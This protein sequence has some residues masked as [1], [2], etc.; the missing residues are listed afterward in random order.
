MGNPILWVLF[1]GV[2]TLVD[3]L[4]PHHFHQSSN[5]MATR[6]IPFS[7]QIGRNLA[8]TKKRVLGEDLVDLAHQFQCFRVESDRRVIQRVI[9]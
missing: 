9:C 6:M 5:T 3:R 8:A 1:A 7:R 2:G 4:Q